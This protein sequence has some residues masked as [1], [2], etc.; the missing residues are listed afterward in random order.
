MDSSQTT[1]DHTDVTGKQKCNYAQ[2][3]YYS[4]A[5]ASTIRFTGIQA[6]PAGARLQMPLNLCSGPTSPSS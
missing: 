6:F 2:R 1:H 5:P 3:T 4:E